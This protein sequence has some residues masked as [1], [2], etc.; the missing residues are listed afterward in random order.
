MLEAGGKNRPAD[1]GGSPRKK[2]TTSTSIQAPKPAVQR[3]RRNRD[4][5]KPQKVD[6]LQPRIEPKRS[7][8]NPWIKIGMKKKVRQVKPT[9]KRKRADT[10]AEVLRAKRIENHLSSLGVDVKSI[11][12][13]T[14]LYM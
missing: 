6:P 13:T 2:E 14:T 11:R 4:K 9:H 10:Y 5:D 3:A 1:D 12:H 7:G 8:E